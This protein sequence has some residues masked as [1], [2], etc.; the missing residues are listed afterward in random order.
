MRPFPPSSELQ[1]LVGQELQQVALD[2]HSV[3]FRWSSGGQITVQYDFEHVDEDGHKHTYD[4]AAFTGPPLL[5][6]RLIQKKVVKLEV[7]ALCLTLVFEG[8]QVLRLRSE[9]G[10]YECGLIQFT[11]NLEDGFV[12]Y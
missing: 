6:H 8:G 4:C 1:F 3:Q 10:P 9:Q 5:L 2:P 12:V 11:D 7:D